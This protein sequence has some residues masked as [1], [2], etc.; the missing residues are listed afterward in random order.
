MK[1]SF[2]LRILI[3][4]A[5]QACRTRLRRLTTLSLVLAAALIPLRAAE[6]SLPELNLKITP[7]AQGLVL[8]WF[9]ELG[10]PFQV[11]G[12][13]DLTNWTDVGPIIGGTNGLV[14]IT[15][16]TNEFQAASSKGT[17]G[18]LGV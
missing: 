1:N 8:T 15:I 5:G 3:N 7:S 6:S 14:S 4:N 17:E 18:Y 10:V 16:A 12:S 11:Q 9:G 13:T 2:C